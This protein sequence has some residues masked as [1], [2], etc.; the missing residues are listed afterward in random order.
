M[1]V[2][3]NTSNNGNIKRRE[4]FAPASEQIPSTGTLDLQCKSVEQEVADPGGSKVP[5]GGQKIACLNRATLPHNICWACL[6]FPEQKQQPHPE[7][8]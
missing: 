4:K 5:N 3:G 7:N 1:Q 8:G 2:T 6:T